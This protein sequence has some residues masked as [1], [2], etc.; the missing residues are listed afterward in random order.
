MN[1]VP[2]GSRSVEPAGE[3]AGPE[4]PAGR[5]GGTG[6]GPPGM[7]RIYFFRYSPMA[8][9][10]TSLTASPAPATEASTTAQSGSMT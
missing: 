6:T 7:E 8:R 9:A 3:G 4:G 1:Q 2:G 5:N 10:T